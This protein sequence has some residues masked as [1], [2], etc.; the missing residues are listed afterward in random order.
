M[1][2]ARIV[3]GRRTAYAT[4]AAR[5]SAAATQDA[6]YGDAKCAEVNNARATAYWWAQDV[7]ARTA[8]GR[9][10]CECQCVTQE[11]ACEVISLMD[12]AC[13]EC[14][15]GDRPATCAITQNYTVYQA[16][17]ADQ[18]TV[19]PNI[20]GRTTLIL[21][22]NNGSF[23]EW[24][25]HVGEIA[26][27]DGAGNFTYTV[28]SSGQIIL[29]DSGNDYYIAFSG[30]VGPLYP[31]INGSLV[32]TN[33][34]LISESPQ[35]NVIAGRE[36]VIA[37]S[38]DGVT[39]TGVYNGSE[40]AFAGSFVATV[41]GSPTLVRSIYI[42]GELEC[43]SSP[44]DG[45]I[46]PPATFRRSFEFL[47]NVNTQEQFGGLVDSGGIMCTD[48]YLDAQWTFAFYIK[49]S[50]GVTDATLMNAEFRGDLAYP[51][52]VYY[53]IYTPN[54][55]TVFGVPLL[56][57]TFPIGALNTNTWTHLAFVKSGSPGDF[58]SLV[59]YVNGVAVLPTTPQGPSFPPGT[60]PPPIG[61][62]GYTIN[63]GNAAFTN[64]PDYIRWAEIYSCNTALSQSDIQNILMT[65]T[66]DGNDG[67]W[68][69]TTYLKPI[70]SDAI[71]TD[72]VN[73]QNYNWISGQSDWYTFTGTYAT[74]SPV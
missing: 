55:I 62:R 30:G 27:D 22:N 69:R 60:S 39:W 1:D 48:W 61:P 16:A 6:I 38:E 63:G 13:V 20:A 41:S 57:A 11:F 14:A 42:Y 37:V 67:A 15:C 54:A 46:P 40:S 50:A 4:C 70:D 21:S 5:F 7:M 51:V 18:Q 34:A 25:Q 24:A 33:L 29:D 35:V 45:E 59:L 9:E 47:Y 17:D 23:N 68:G 74:D 72:A 49:L 8:I 58:S 2:F 19:L 52:E 53:G 73:A 66:V 43:Q 44:V 56:G 10:S 36:I 3:Q 28:P 26:T 71:G 65:G 32:G 12:P 64:Y 31:V